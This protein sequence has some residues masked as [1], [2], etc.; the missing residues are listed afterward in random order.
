HREN[1]TVVYLEVLGFWSREA[2]WRRVELAEA[3]LETPVLFC[4][5][6]RLRV[7]EQIMG[8]DGP[9]ALYVYKSALLAGVVREKL[10]RLAARAQRTR[11]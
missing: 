9:A 8:E 4:A 5:S 11:E 1:G 7:S 2:V 6:E 10:D 3:G